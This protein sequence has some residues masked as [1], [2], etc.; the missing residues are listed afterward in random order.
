MNG[1]KLN[2]NQFSDLI[3]LN[4]KVFFPLVNFV[5]KKDFE[6]IIKKSLFNKK[7][8]PYPIFFGINKKNY[9]R[10]KNNKE[11]FFFYKSKIIAKVNNIN[12]FQ[13]NKKEFGYKIYGK[14]YE[15]HPYYR[16]FKLENYRFLNF[17]IKKIYKFKLSKSFFVSPDFF[18]NK[19]KKKKLASFH[20]RN[21]PHR[22]HQWIHKY[23][24]KKYNSLLIQPLIGQYKYGEY[25]DNVIIK[26]NKKIVKQYKNKNVFVIPFFS[27]PRYGGPRE[28]AL[29]AIV[30]KNFGCSHFWVGRDHAGYKQFFQKYASQ[31]FCK[32]N[33]KKLKI[34]IVTLKEPYYCSNKKFIVNHCNC[35]IPCKISVSGS[36][37][38]EMIKKN[39]NIPS[40]LMSKTI[41]KNLDKSSLII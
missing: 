11:L 21:V 26:L 15:K 17:D 31:K 28:A 35:K 25:K 18:K 8:F 40:Y 16:K 2:Q 7:F 41:S 39:I 38:R 10:F 9:I 19:N 1:L 33:S 29:H 14:N 23:L 30:R 4:N 13:I 24:I 12:F 32:K 36:S 5:N 6:S 20:T 3:N 22:A 27:Y 37:I 34:N